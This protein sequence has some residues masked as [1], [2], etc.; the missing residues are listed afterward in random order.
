MDWQ[1]KYFDNLEIQIREIKDELRQTENRVSVHIREA[2]HKIYLQTDQ[3]HR[4]YIN[5][6][7]RIDELIARVDKRQD[8]LNKWVL[9]ASIAVLL[10]VASL[11]STGVFGFVKFVEM[12]GRH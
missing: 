5:V 2:M 6:N 12:L 10:G 3:R 11:V 9:R 7:E 8:D 4:E 1:Q